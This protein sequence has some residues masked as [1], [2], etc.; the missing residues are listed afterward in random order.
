M[1]VRDSDHAIGG[2]CLDGKGIEE[3]LNGHVLVLEVI[4]E[5]EIVLVSEELFLCLAKSN[6]VVGF[7]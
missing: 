3:R 1:A 6:R 7:P 2:A 4:E 5:G